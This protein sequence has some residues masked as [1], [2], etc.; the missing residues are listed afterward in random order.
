MEEAMAKREQRMRTTM[1]SPAPLQTTAELKSLRPL[2]D[3]AWRAFLGMVV[4]W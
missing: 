2:Q 4:E 3:C 1:L